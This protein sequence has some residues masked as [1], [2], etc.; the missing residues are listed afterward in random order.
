MTNEGSITD[1]MRETVLKNALKFACG[2]AIFCPAC[3]KILDCSRAVSVDFYQH[4]TLA[5]TRTTCAGCYDSKVKPRIDAAADR[6]K[7][8]GI[9]VEVSDGRVL[10]AKPKRVKASKPAAESPK[11]GKVTLEQVMQAIEDDDHTGYCTACGASQGELEPDARERICLNC[12]AAAVYGAEE[13][14]V[15]LA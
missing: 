2:Q 8:E 13:L 10:F 3:Q 11:L 12:G 7:A 6:I 9:K 14:L 5:G 1:V 15:M 4:G